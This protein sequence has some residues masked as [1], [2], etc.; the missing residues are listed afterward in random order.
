MS[1]SMP[2]RQA[3]RGGRGGGGPPP[4]RRE[5]SSYGQDAP[6]LITAEDIRALRQGQRDIQRSLEDKIDRLERLLSERD[7]KI[8]CLEQRVDDLEQYS[9]RDDIIISGLIIEKTA[10]EVVKGDTE[11]AT[12]TEQEQ[13]TVEKE[14]KNKTEEKVLEFLNGKGVQ[15]SGHEISACHTIGK[16]NEDTGSHRV[17]VRF[18]SR[19]CKNNVISQSRNLKGSGVYL[20]DHLTTKNAGLAK[21]ARD[22]RRGEEI[23][24][25]W[26]RNCK[27]F[28]KEKSGKVTCVKSKEDLDAVRNRPAQ[29]FREGRYAIKK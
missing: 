10:A 27:I 7:A 9:R 20:N 17:I 19:K 16:R 22:L 6:V 18:V 26:V 13:K 3:G 4:A 1:G 28:V 29:E 2:A 8:A 24:D 5:S 12:E 21:D 23:M 15:I 11:G 14:R 25:T